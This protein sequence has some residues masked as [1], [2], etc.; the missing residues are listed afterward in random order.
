MERCGNQSL[1]IFFTSQTLQPYPMVLDRQQNSAFTHVLWDVL[2]YV[3]CP[4]WFFV[5]F[6]FFVVF[7]TICPVWVHT[8][9]VF[10][11]IGSYMGSRFAC[12]SHYEI[13]LDLLLFYCLLSSRLT[14]YKK[15]DRSFYSVW[16]QSV[17]FVWHSEFTAHYRASC[18]VSSVTQWE[19]TTWVRDDFRHS[20]NFLQSR[21]RHYMSGSVGLNATGKLN[22]QCN[23]SDVSFLSVC[24][25][26]YL[27]YLWCHVISCTHSGW[28]IC[29]F[30]SEPLSLGFV[31]LF[32][33]LFVF[34]C[35]Y[36]L[37]YWLAGHITHFT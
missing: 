3:V 4:Y 15:A 35:L 18:H 9:Y 34:S 33:C 37:Q 36:E 11:M 2:W 13:L 12:S 8:T 10:C 22:L 24:M 6:C 26:V 23:I 31:F 14:I 16:I 30:A 27:M 20:P 28:L 19:A 25:F 7:I 17:K 21:G 29:S 5:C 1:T 32:W